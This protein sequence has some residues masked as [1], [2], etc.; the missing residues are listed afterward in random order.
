MCVCVCV[1]SVYLTALFAYVCMYY[2][3]VVC[4]ICFF[5]RILAVRVITI[6]LEL[7]N[8]VQETH[9]L[10]IRQCCIDC[11]SCFKYFV[12]SMCRRIIYKFNY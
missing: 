2:F 9:D 6:T 12:V 7:V 4:V 8:N 10:E 3:S 5:E 11:Y 1:Y